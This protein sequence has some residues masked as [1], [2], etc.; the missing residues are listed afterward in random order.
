MEIYDIHEV[1]REELSK[2]KDFIDC[3]WKKNH[4]LVLSRQLLDFQ[5]LKDDKYS[6]LVAENT[7][8]HEFDALIGFIP[9]SQ[10]DCGLRENGDYWMAIWKKRDDV[11]N[12]EIGLIGIQLFYRLLKSSDIKSIGILGISETAKKIYAALHLRISYLNQWYMLNDSISDYK[13]VKNAEIIQETPYSESDVWDIGWIDPTE[14]SSQKIVARY[15]PMKSVT[16]FLNRYA[17]HPLYTYRFLGIYYDNQLECILA[18]R[19]VYANGAKAIR[20][21]DALGSVGGMIGRKLKM[22]MI[23]ENAEYIDFLNH[24][25]PDETFIGM[26]FRLLDFDGNMIVPCYFEPFEQR[27][28]RID[29]AYK[30]SFNYVAFKGDGDQ[31]RPSV[32]NL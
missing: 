1:E 20:V 11:V 7:Q 23:E 18:T 32:I 30:A 6:F 12:N 29:L 22:L 14:L 10:F 21:I 2:L 19:D 8:T 24:G 3:H 27:N 13:I 9:T 15:R 28:V 26:G 16:Y 5:H 17:S 25:I 4:A 31:D